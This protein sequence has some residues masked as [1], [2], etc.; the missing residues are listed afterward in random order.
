MLLAVSAEAQEIRDRDKTQATNGINIL[1][2]MVISYS[3][4]DFM[5][6]ICY[7]VS[8][9][10]TIKSLSSA[11]PSHKHSGQHGDG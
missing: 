2:Y 3:S 4:N 8:I 5:G 1:L 11:I 9:I 10:S 7:K 6:V